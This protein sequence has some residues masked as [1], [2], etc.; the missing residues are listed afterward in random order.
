MLIPFVN[1]E[2]LQEVKGLGA[3]WCQSWSLVAHNEAHRNPASTLSKGS[4][5]NSWSDGSLNQSN[6]FASLSGNVATSMTN[7]NLGERCQD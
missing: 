5:S 2:V 4:G 3:V 7:T 6:S 1:C